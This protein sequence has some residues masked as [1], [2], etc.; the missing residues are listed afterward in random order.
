MSI[1][2][3][4]FSKKNQSMMHPDDGRRIDWIS[5]A[6]I[7][8][9][10]GVSILFIY[11]AQYTHGGGDWKK[12]LFWVA[13][14]LSTYSIVSLINYK[15]FLGYAHF[16]YA[17]GIFGLLLATK[18]SPI[19]VEMMGARRWIDVGVTIVQPTEGAKI[20]TLIMIASIL[21]RSELGSVRDSLL[22]LTKVAVVFLIP[23]LLIFLQPDLGSS[24]VFPPMIFAL[25][26]VSRL[27]EKFFVSAFALFAVAVSVV[28]LDIYAYSQHLE[29]ERAAEVSGTTLT[30]EEYHSLLP[31][32]NYQRNRILTFVAPDVV[33][34]EGTGASWNA[35]QAK[36]SAATGGLAGKGLFKGTQAQ[37]GY[38]PQAVAHN[39]FIFSVIAEETGFLGSAFVVG[40]FC[41]MVAN[42]IR[43]AGLARDRFGMQ[44]AI[45]VSVL[46]LVHFFINIGMT[47]GITPITGLPLPF[48]SYGG[49]FVLSCFILQGLVQSVYRYRKDYT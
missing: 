38:L 25:L 12:Q 39:D 44:L 48:L 31:I 26:Y 21:A 3:R 27:S 42:G 11:S 29:Q 45:G 4:I 36:I 33:D 32:H 34:P 6:C 17:A 1:Y 22:V 28:G 19:S 41:L 23:M 18:I 46:F 47:I 10:C 8:L 37:L 2:R 35:K 13:L 16:I 24:L 43:I 40:L 20:G 14:G 7:L 30:T 5:P 9:L 15:V 49:S